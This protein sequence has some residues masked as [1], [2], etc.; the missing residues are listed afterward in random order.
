V[1]EMAVFFMVCSGIA[2]GVASLDVGR[3]FCHPLF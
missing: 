1:D 3:D 2:I